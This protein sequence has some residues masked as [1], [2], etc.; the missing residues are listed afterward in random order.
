[1]ANDISYHRAGVADIDV[2]IEFRLRFLAEHA[3]RAR[4]PKED[5]L[6][7]NLMDYFEKAMPAGDF[8]AW[9]A[10]QDGK[11][12]GTSGIVVW[13]MPPNNSVKTGKQGYILNMY[14][15]PEA[16]R[17]GI[18]TELLERMIVEAK[19]L[20]LSRV[21]LHASKLGEDI[22]RRRGFRE[23]GDIELLLRLD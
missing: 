18:C 10:K 14:T 9:L 3:N 11:V 4:L 20:G 22:Y 12:I 8:I 6:R 21:H 16:R 5:E 17:K 13:R 23:P 1:L 15:V 19:A 2:L 7:K